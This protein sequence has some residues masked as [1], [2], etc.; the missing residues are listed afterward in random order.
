MHETIKQVPDPKNKDK[1]IDKKWNLPEM[2]E[3]KWKTAGECEEIARALGWGLRK[4][5]LEQ[6][7]R[8]AICDDTKE[9]WSLTAYGAYSQSMVVVTVYVNL[10]EEKMVAALNECNVRVFQTDSAHLQEV[11]DNIDDLKDLHTLIITDSIEKGKGKK[12]AEA[13]RK[14]DINVLEWEDV[15]ETGRKERK[16][17][18]EEEK[19]VAPKPEDIAV[20]MYTSGTTGSPK[21]VIIKHKNMIANVAASDKVV[22]FDSDEDVYLAYL[23]LAHVLALILEAC[24]IYNGVRIGYGTP[25]SLMDDSVKNCKGDVRALQPTIFPVVPAV[26]NKLKRAVHGKVG[27][28][29]LPLRVRARRLP[30]PSCLCSSPAFY[31]L[32]NGGSTKTFIS[33]AV[34][35]QFRF[36]VQEGSGAEG[37]L[38]F[39]LGSLGLQQD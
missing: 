39:H 12:A 28:A 38:H 7:D 13:L 30:I 35:V 15:L 5:G 16:G 4:L 34:V 6:K 11:L 9:K 37:P 14:R 26:S 31:P 27:G 33:T 18:E 36:L 2:S 29:F 24:C 32:V 8:L 23:P 10:G 19:K 20:I 1:K 17:K 22:T 21:G 25:R 3:Y